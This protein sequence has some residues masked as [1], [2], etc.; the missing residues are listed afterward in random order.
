MIRKNIKVHNKKVI[1]D[2]REEAGFINLV[3]YTT[4]VFPLPHL[5]FYLKPEFRKRG[6]M[7]KELPKYLKYLNK[8]ENYQW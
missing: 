2:G 4:K 8:Y 7:S 6:I 5:E 1:Y 3:S